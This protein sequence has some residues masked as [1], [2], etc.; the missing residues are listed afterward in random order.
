[1]GWSPGLFNNSPITE[2]RVALSDAGGATLS[3]TSCTITVGCTVS[4]P[5]N[6]P[7]YAVRI[8]IVAVNEIGESEPAQLPGTI[9]SDVIPPPPV[10]VT[11]TPLDHGLRVVWRKPV[12]TAGTPIDSYVVSVAGQSV[13]VTVSSEDAAGTE[14]SRSI[15]G[16]AIANG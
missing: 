11:S 6:G 9:W 10:G 3:T 13:T 14:Y 12:T 15:T 1:L 7:D 8:S 16:S 4:T 2:Y 5:G